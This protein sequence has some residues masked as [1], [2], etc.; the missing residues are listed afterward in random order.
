MSEYNTIIY[1]PGLVTKIIHNE[2]ETHN[3]TGAEF[4]R[5][6]IDA[7]KRFEKDREAKVAVTLANGKH[8]CAGH[9]IAFLSEKQSWK[10]GEKV[11]WA[12]DTWR[13][14]ND[15]RRFDAP[16]WD[17]TKPLVVGA[18]GAVLA[19]GIQ[20][21][22]MHDIVV[23]GENAFIGTAINRVSGAFGGL[24]QMWL[25]YRKT[26]ELLNTGWNI[27]SK[28]LYRL[29]AINKVVPD[30]KVAEAAIRYAEI[31]ALMP[32]ELL[33][34]QKQSL[35]FG[36]NLMGAREQIWHNQETNTL[37]HCA[38]TEEEKQFYTIM[39]TEGMKAALDFRDKPFEKYGF[40]RN[41]ATEI[42]NDEKS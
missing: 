18:Q 37:V 41:K 36:M 39:K 2:P 13:F 42:W 1:E 24:L 8:F 26:F 3:V 9:N 23:M 40:N 31:I 30:E 28:E 7:M 20:L 34:L 10:P 21:L 16:L 19:A 35:K 17:V 6:Y 11:E 33:K 14:I 5:E 4:E 22:M 38:P 27:S 15:A 12:E 29:G 32:L 25:G